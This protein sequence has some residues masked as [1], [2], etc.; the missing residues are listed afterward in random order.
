[1]PYFSVGFKSDKIPLVCRERRGKEERGSPPLGNLSDFLTGAQD[2]KD[3]FTIS[4]AQGARGHTFY[5]GPG[6]HSLYHRK[7]CQLRLLA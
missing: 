6:R 5:E 2:S 4:R 7:L 1:M 3:V